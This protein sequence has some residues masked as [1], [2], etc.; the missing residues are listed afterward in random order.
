MNEWIQHG[1]CIR[2]AGPSQCGKTSALC[3]LS[4]SKEYSFLAHKRVMWVSD[5]GAPAESFES[6]IKNVY[7]A[8]QFFYQ[9]AAGNDISGM[10]QEYD[11]CV[12]HDMVSEIKNITSLPKLPITKLSH[13][14][15]HAK[16]L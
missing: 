6:K 5:P 14:L 11:F 2:F 12:F 15:P 13:G 4:A 9:V 16:C 8:S 7:P 10:V 3:N 1:Y